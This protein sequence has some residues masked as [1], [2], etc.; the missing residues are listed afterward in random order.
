MA[1]RYV[2]PRG[3]F[4]YTKVAEE[5][6]GVAP[7]LLLGAIRRGELKA[8]VKPLTRGRKE[9][10]TQERNVVMVCLADV[11]KWIRTYWQPAAAI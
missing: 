4:P 8:Y 10:A 3:W 2:I 6:L 11:D 5:Y 9:G 7:Y 1:D